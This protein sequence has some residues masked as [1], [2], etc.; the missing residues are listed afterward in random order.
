MARNKVQFQKGLSLVDFLNNYG[1]E[2]DCFDSLHQS[3]WPTG[4]ICP[5]CG[6]DKYCRLTIR[7]LSQCNRCHRQTSLT[8]GTIFESTKLPLKTWFLGIYFITQDKKG[9]ST[10]KLHRQLGISYNAAWRMKHKLMQVMMER[11]DS[12]P[13]SGFVE[14]DDAYMGGERTGC[15]RGRGA[16]GK[17][18]FVAAVETTQNNEPVKVKLTVVPG[19]RK[20]AIELWAKQH[21]TEGT[22]VISD[23]LACFN[24]V[25]DAGCEHERI[26][27][28]GGRASVEEPKFYWVNTVLG[29]L[30]SAIRSTY[31]SINQKYV[32]RYLSEFQYLF[33]RRFDLEA[34]IPRLLYMSLRT[35]PMPE[36]LLKLGLA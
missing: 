24:A 32:Q 21:L 19:F 31:H 11:D 36:K 1:T 27:C 20:T 29:N 8:A 23:G 13:L 26:V 3:R 22:T 34:I 33:N 12:Q 30:K 10:M 35:P 18:P 6:Y 9:V 14:L 4:F 17:T 28:G 5:H 16:E 15:K 2:D 25:T 7:K